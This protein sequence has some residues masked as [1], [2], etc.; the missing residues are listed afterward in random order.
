MNNIT[1]YE[2][3]WQK[4]EDM[5]KFGPASLHCRRISKKMIKNLSYKSVLD[6]GCGQGSLLLELKKENKGKEFYGL[7]ISEKAISLAK[8]KAPFAKFF[9]LD[10]QKNHLKKKFDL[11]ITS[12]ILEHLEDD[13]KALKN[14]RKMSKNYLLVYTLKGRMRPK[15]IEVGHVRNYSE[16]ELL[17]KIKK[18]GFL[19]KKVINWG[20][21]FYSPL[22]RDFL[23]KFPSKTTYGKFGF[24]RKLISKII[25]YIFYLNSFKKGDVIVVLAKVK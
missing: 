11:I 19:I 13:Q 12:E 20:F 15:E 14:I 22:Y 21:P 9:I 2:K 1:F 17:D 5:K 16:K 8:K 6:I 18:A 23:E 24:L 7:D 25:Y 4:W 10:I 3:S